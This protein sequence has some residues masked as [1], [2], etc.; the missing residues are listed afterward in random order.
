MADESEAGAA[1]LIFNEGIR[2]ENHNSIA[3]LE[4]G[5]ASIY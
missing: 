5:E 3:V 2:N 1:N 4:K